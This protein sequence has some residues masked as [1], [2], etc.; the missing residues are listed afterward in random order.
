MKILVDENI[1]RMT[2]ARLRELGHDVMDIRGTADQG[3][4]D[5][6]LWSVA[7]RQ[8]RL[9]ITTDKGL[10][11]YRAVAHHGILIVRLRQPNRAKIHQSV[12]IAMER[13]AEREW[14]G[15]LVV[16]QDATMSTSRGHRRS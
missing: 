7:V 16:M 2:A 1:P 13:F 8:E 5:P 4:P 9:L 12:M 10:T 6:D 14:A 11:E 15:L 3:L